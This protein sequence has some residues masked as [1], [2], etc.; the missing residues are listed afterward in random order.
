MNKRW[1]NFIKEKKFAD[2]SKGKGQWTD[3]SVSDLK[4]P[5][6]VDTIKC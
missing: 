5:T 1:K 4:D 6:N 3:L 2:F